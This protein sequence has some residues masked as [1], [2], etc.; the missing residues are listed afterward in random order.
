MALVSSRWLANIA[1]RML[2]PACCRY[3]NVASGTKRTRGWWGDALSLRRSSGS[4]G[5][6]RVRERENDRN[7]LG[8]CESV[9]GLLGSR[10]MVAELW[11][12]YTHQKFQSSRPQ[13]IPG[14]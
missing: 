6:R 4:S 8:G 5:T 9:R 3:Q 13:G 14:S 1:L 10:L 7:A 11:N 2:V 12:L